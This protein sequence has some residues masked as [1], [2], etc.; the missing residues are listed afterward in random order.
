MSSVV[1]TLVMKNRSSRRYVGQDVTVKDPSARALWFPEGGHRSPDGHKISGNVEHPRQWHRVTLLRVARGQ[2]A[3]VRAMHMHRVH[4]ATGIQ[5]H[6]AYFAAQ[7]VFQ[8]FSVG[9]RLSVDHRNIKRFLRKLAVPPH[10]ND[11]YA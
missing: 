8:S 5:P 10:S 7:R 9:P 11:E 2:H 6:P 4:I 3:E 1:R